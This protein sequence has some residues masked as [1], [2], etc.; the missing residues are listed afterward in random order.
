M[1]QIQAAEDAGQFD[2]QSCGACCAYSADWPRFSTEP[3]TDLDLIPEKLVAVDLGG[4]ACDGERCRAL[5]GEVGKAATC[6]IYQVRPVVCRT[7]MPGDAECLT[8]R[9]AFGL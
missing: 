8:A 4:M 1:N 5:K 7:C 3:E 2:C 6:T 9:A